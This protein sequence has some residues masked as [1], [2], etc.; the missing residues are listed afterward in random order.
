MVEYTVDIFSIMSQFEREH[1]HRPMWFKF[2]F[3][4]EKIAISESK[5][6]TFLYTKAEWPNFKKE[7][8]SKMIYFD[9]SECLDAK[10]DKIMYI[11]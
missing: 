11:I 10:C 6:T 9:E 4:R 7:V 1:Y 3:L 8:E 2:D 5:N